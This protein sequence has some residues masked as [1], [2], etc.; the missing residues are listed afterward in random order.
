MGEHKPVNILAIDTA[1]ALLSVALEAP[2]GRYVFE[3][4]GAG[5]HAERL[6]VIIEW[7]LENAGLRR[8]ELELVSCMEGPGSFTGLRIG[9]AAAK[10][11]ALAL[12]IP[13]LPVP[14]LDCL[15]LPH[16]AW[17]GPVVA[18]MDAKKKRFFAAIYRRGEKCT[19]DLDAAPEEIAALL[20]PFCENGDPVFLAGPDTP[21]LHA[22]LLPFT[23][24]APIAPDPAYRRGASGA[25]LDISRKRGIVLRENCFASD[26]AGPVYVRKSDAELQSGLKNGNDEEQRVSGNCGSA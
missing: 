4:D 5:S 20:A 21:L 10:G 8:E 15:A 22:A 11:L 12:G 2:S 17:P 24:T 16:A 1:S 6:M 7:L 19:A 9:F 13:L 18:A 3:G 14:T 25:L 26:G 23:L